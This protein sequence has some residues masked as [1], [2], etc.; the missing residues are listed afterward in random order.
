MVAFKGDAFCLQLSRRT[1]SGEGK[2][3]RLRPGVSEYL[4]PDQAILPPGGAPHHNPPTCR[5]G[6]GRPPP[7]SVDYT[8]PF[9]P[10]HAEGVA[11]TWGREQPWL[12]VHTALGA[13]RSLRGTIQQHQRGESFL[14]GSKSVVMG[15]VSLRSPLRNV[16]EASTVSGR[17]GSFRLR[18]LQQNKIG[19]PSEV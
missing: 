11:P 14:S 3:M 7:W 5:R 12:G 16:S 2:C 17:L 13:E 19:A 8:F 10:S 6:R 18:S 1:A 4:H 15:A 9:S